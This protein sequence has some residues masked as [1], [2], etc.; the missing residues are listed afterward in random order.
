MVDWPVV[1]TKV[2]P[3]EVTVLTRAEVVMA[4]L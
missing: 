4:E 1:V 2:L 3:S